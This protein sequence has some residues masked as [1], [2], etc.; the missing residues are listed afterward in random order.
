MLHAYYA[1]PNVVDTQKGFLEGN[2]NYSVMTEVTLNSENQIYTDEESTN[3]QLG[4]TQMN[5]T[6]N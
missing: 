4:N 1:T 3:L 2:F 5:D 6:N